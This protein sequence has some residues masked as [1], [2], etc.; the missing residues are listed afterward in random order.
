MEKEEGTVDEHENTSDREDEEDGGGVMHVQPLFSDV[1]ALLL[2]AHVH[3][4][5]PSK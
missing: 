3:R 5:D 1:S 2:M 4:G